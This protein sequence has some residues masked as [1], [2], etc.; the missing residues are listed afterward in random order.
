MLPK[1]PAFWCLIQPMEVDMG[2]YP[3]GVKY[4][5]LNRA[6]AEYGADWYGWTG[7]NFYTFPNFSDLTKPVDLTKPADPTKL[8]AELNYDAA[9][10]FNVIRLPIAW[11]RLQHTPKG[12]LDE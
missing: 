5:G 10:G 7:N 1:C 6:G 8:A 2:I 3:T 11:E 9:K 12:H 4:R